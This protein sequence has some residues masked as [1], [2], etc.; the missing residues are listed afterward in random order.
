M[1]RIGGQHVIEI[2]A[3]IC[4]LANIVEERPS[5]GP[6]KARVL[7]ASTEDEANDLDRLTG[8]QAL[9]R[10]LLDNLATTEA[11]RDQSLQRF[12]TIAGARKA[13]EPSTF[14]KCGFARP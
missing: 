7:L 14:S 4:K 6:R 13:Y 1:N 2:D 9:G 8:I 3:D 10:S 11:T 5:F 12:H